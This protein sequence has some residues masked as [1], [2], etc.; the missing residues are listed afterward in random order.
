MLKSYSTRLYIGM[1]L[2]VGVLLVGGSFIQSEAV[3]QALIK[4]R[5]QRLTALAKH[6]ANRLPADYKE[7][8][9]KK[10]MANGTKAEQ[11]KALNEELQPI[12][13]SYSTAFPDVEMGYFDLRLTSVVAIGPKF[14]DDLLVDLPLDHPYLKYVRT[15]KTEVIKNPTSIAW[16]G[17]P[18]LGVTYPIRK[19][20]RIIGHAWANM[21]TEDIIAVTAY[22]R[23]KLLYISSGIFLIG[24]MGVHFISSRSK[25]TLRQF[26]EYMKKLHTGKKPVCNIEELAP[27]IEEVEAIQK[28]HLNLAL[29]NERL[30]TI[31]Q[32]AAGLA[33]DIRNPLTS[34]RGFLQLISTRVTENDREMI[35]ISLEELD[36]IN[37]L[38]K[39]MLYL[40][41]PP[42]SNFIRADLGQ[43]INKIKDFI[44]PEANL[45]EIV[46]RTRIQPDLPEAFIDPDQMR[47]V[48]INLLRNSLEAVKC[49]GEILIS[50]YS[51]GNHIAVEI[52][53]NGVGIPE[54]EQEKIFDALYTT[55]NNGTGLGLPICKEIITK[56]KGKMLLESEVGIGTV[57]N[58]LLPFINC[59]QELGDEFTDA[60]NVEYNGAGTGEASNSKV[61]VKDDIVWT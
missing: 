58:V 29:Q 61:M 54:A 12:I 18:I 51:V 9:I 5:E 25:S 59:W 27:L 38:I 42:K 53:D 14:F 39:D 41:R 30:A 24:M 52:K 16:R 6:L 28:K 20:G 43:M 21:K 32:L 45:K 56:H 55:K 19:N 50:V 48:F 33:H 3:Y 8:L 34:V 4:S 11:I 22:A 26:A 1:V 2:L 36:D 17:K 15:G 60:P 44:N 49:K 37:R 10:G 57:V 40:A 7:I 31:A 13:N 23:R 46:L 47:Q 35:N